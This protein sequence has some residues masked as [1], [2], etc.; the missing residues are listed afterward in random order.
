MKLVKRLTDNYK[1]NPESNIGKLLSIIDFELDRLKE[2]YKL[3]DSYRA[4]D[5]ATGATLDNIGKNVLQER[6]GMD[7]VTYRLFL[8]TRIKSNLSGGQIKTIN[9][10]LTANFG[11]NFLGIREVWGDADYSNEPAAFEVSYLNFFDKVK[12]LYEYGEDDPWFLNGV[13]FLDGTRKLDGGYSFIYADF[14][15]RI[16]EYMRLSKEIIQ[17]VT[18]AGVQTWWNE[19]LE[20]ESLIE[21]ENNVTITIEVA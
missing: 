4:I 13:Y 11:E 21:I 2:T 1:K 5:N 16:I 19:V 6:G 3:I 7:D 18:S 10:I 14:E 17:N 8:K 20:T 12:A 15:A 9:E